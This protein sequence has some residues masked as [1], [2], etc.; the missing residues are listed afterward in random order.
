MHNIVL[1]NGSPRING[2]TSMK[3]LELLQSKYGSDCNMK[4]L[5][6][7]KSIIHKTQ[8]LDYGCMAKADAIVIAFPLY[9][10]C[11]P[12][13]LVEYLSGYRDYRKSIGEATSPKIYAIINCGFP[14]A[15]INDDAAHVIK[16]MCKEI[17]AKYRFSVLIGGGGMLQPMKKFPPVHK[18]WNEIEFTFA[19]IARDVYD[20]KIS[21]KKD[22][23][24][25]VFKNIHIDSKVPKKL[26]YFIAQTN[27]FVAAKINGIKKKEI[28]RR[29]YLTKNS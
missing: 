21:D 24:A 5:E 8:T 26:F 10:Y 23:S 16:N 3:L 12:G 1:L 27:F 7:A 11:L 19:Q 20:E 2:S 14:E 22:C 25:K 4:V 18:M 6:V 28:F 29:P 9:V 15:R 13:V 17:G